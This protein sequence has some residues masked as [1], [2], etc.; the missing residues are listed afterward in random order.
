MP[1]VFWLQAQPPFRL[2]LTAWAIRRRPEN[3]IDLWD[4]ARYRR[5][6]ALHGKAAEISVTQRTAA[7]SRLRVRLA[8]S[9]LDVSAR[10]QV[11]SALD[12][13]L[14]RRIDL[15]P[16]YRHANQDRRLSHLVHRF[17]GLKPPRIPSVFEAL[18]NGIACQQLSLAV[19]ITLLN[20]LSEAYGVRFREADHV[21][22]SF[23]PPELLACAKLQDLRKLGFSSNKSRALIELASA[24]ASGQLDLERLETIDN[25]EAVDRLLTIRGVGRWTA[26]YVL[27]RG[28][29]RTTVFPG[30]DVGARNNLFHWLRLRKPLDYRGVSR[31]LRKWRSYAGLIY[32]H[33]LMDRLEAAG[34]VK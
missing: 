7:T 2:G 3:K 15:Q 28:L 34:Y 30:D 31:A 10:A 26:E 9:D 13:L 32:F 24:V 23:A 6:L 17:Y 11:T 21:Q 27:L 5:V 1:A 18:V 22:Y 33:L 25:E 29:G 14:G 12:R 19:G 16:F 20:R 4:G 8:G